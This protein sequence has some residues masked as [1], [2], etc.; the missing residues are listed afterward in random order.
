MPL[1]DD[2]DGAGPQGCLHHCCQTSNSGQKQSQSCILL[3]N[4]QFDQS[5]SRKAHPCFMWDQ[6]VASKNQDSLSGGQGVLVACRSPARAEAR[7]LPGP[8]SSQRP[9]CAR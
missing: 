1:R 8:A 6:P 7:P 5:S 2:A 9:G 4:L 3:T